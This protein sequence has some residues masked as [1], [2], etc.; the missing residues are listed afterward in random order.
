MRDATVAELAEVGAKRISVGGALA[1]LAMAA[2]AN[3]SRMLRDE[4]KFGWLEG[5]A[6]AGE[7]DGLLRAGSG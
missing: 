2:V 5:L 1:G 7:I 3:A 6:P 4:G